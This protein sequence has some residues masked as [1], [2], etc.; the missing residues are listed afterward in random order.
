MLHVNMLCM[1]FR[2][3]TC[4][5]QNSIQ[6]YMVLDGH[7]GVRA[8][9]FS[10]GFI[11]HLLLHSELVGG[12]QVVMKALRSA[13]VRTE[14]EFF[15]GIDPYITRKVTLQLEIEVSLAF[16]ISLVQDKQFMVL[17]SWVF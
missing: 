7:D 11:P 5:Y 12:D 15:I 14:R 6:L 10:Q 13:I 2:C 1:L 9:N 16:F 17:D 3:Y 4:I 8:V